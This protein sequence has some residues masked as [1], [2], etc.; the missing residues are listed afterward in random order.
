MHKVQGSAVALLQ[1]GPRAETKSGYE[2]QS[3][4]Q[5]AKSAGRCPYRCCIGAQCRRLKEEIL[6]TESL[7]LGSVSFN[8]G[9]F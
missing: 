6:L 7:E 4:P 9:Q 8:S 1:A 5:S 3:F 2:N